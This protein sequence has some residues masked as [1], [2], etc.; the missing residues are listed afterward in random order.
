[1]QLL[2]ILLQ[3]STAFKV[4]H[5]TCDCV[6]DDNYVVYTSSLYKLVLEILLRYRNDVTELQR[7][8]C[9]L[10]MF[11]VPSLGVY[12]VKVTVAF[13]VRLSRIERDI[14]KVVD[15][16]E[17]ELLLGRLELLDQFQPLPASARLEHDR[18]C[19]RQDTGLHQ[20]TWDFY[21]VYAY[22]FEPIQTKC[23]HRSTVESAP[24]AAASYNLYERFLRI[25]ISL[26]VLTSCFS[27]LRILHDRKLVYVLFYQDG[28][29]ILSCSFV[30]TL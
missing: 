18:A 25:Y 8:D 30:C 20:R 28:S 2:Q 26:H 1:M 17:T 5:G 13:S 14:V 7:L 15:D 9:G 21:S 3:R 4:P 10:V 27:L 16:S 6:R 23:W 22:A 24:T 11:F 29:C 19:G 12:G